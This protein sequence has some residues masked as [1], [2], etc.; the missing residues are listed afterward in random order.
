MLEFCLVGHKKK[1]NSGGLSLTT[2]W[3]SSE[4]ADAIFVISAIHL[5]SCCYFCC[6][7]SCC[8][9][10]NISSSLTIYLIQL[11]AFC[12]MD[13]SS[14]SSL[15]CMPQAFARCIATQHL[16]FP[17][18]R[19]MRFLHF[20]RSI[21]KGKFPITCA[22]QSW[23]LTSNFQCSGG[24]ERLEVEDAELKKK[25]NVW[26]RQRASLVNECHSYGFRGSVELGRFY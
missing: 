13:P 22:R 11:V 8:L 20:I 3:P 6:L 24:G 1:K 2:I 25:K 26:V 5:V 9:L 15:S 19:P 12:K 17:S 10:C 14:K 18:I 21:P 16:R 4:V 7:C 23:R